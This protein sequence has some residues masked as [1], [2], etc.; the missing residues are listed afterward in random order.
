MN[1]KD[2]KG[3]ILGFRDI[4]YI[5]EKQMENDME[6]RRILE[7][8]CQGN[9]RNSLEAPK[10]KTPKPLSPKLPGQPLL[11]GCAYWRAA[12][13]VLPRLSGRALNLLL[14]LLGVA[15]KDLKNLRFRV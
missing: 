7:A 5:M 8:P 12:W 14:H 15:V 9:D 4:Y 10:H 13:Q 6:L 11:L 3:N 1:G 2:N